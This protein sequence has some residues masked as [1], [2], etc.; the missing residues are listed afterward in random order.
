ML[1][2]TGVAAVTERQ[3]TDHVVEAWRAGRGGSIVTAN[4]DILRRVGRDP[5]ARSLVQRS[6]LVV[7]DGMPL[8]W[9]ASLAGHHLPERVTGASLFWSLSKVAAREE[10]PVFV[11]GGPPGAADGAAAA[12]VQRFPD[13][14]I[15]GTAC[16]PLGFDRTPDA[17]AALAEEVASTRPGLVLVGLGF[18]K[19]ERVAAHIRTVLPTAWYLGCGAAVVFAAG[20]VPRAPEWMQ[21]SGLEWAHR[22][23]QEPRRMAGR[24]LR[25]DLPFTAELFASALTQRLRAPSQLPAGAPRD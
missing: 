1:G 25:D 2:G 20:Q 16:P 22:L 15:A 11:L 10:Q 6:D 9:A 17:M 23:L 21:R 14:R 19:Q 24:Y 5:S 8:L 18:P 12:L 3:A 13:V 4:V 7:A